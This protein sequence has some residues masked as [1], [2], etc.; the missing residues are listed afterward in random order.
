MK[1]KQLLSGFLVAMLFIFGCSPDDP[2]FIPVEDR[3][4][5]E[6]QLADNDSIINYLNTHYYN[7][8]ELLAMT[9]PTPRDIVLKE[10]TGTPDAGYSLLFGDENLITQTTTFEDTQYTFYVLKINQG[11]GEKSPNFTD[12]VRVLYEGSLVAQNNSVFDSAVTPAD[13]DLV[14][15]SVGIGVIQGW[16]NV[17]PFFNEAA[18]FTTG[19]S[20]TYDDFGL[21]VMFLPSGLAYFSSQLSGIPS[22]SNLIFKFA[23]LQTEVNDHDQDGIPSYIEDL[24]GNLNTFD[25]DT[26]EDTQPNYFDVDDDGDGVATIFELFPTEYIVDTNNNEPEPV[27][28]DG[29]FE[30]SRSEVSGIVTINT[31]TIVDDNNNGIAD[32]LDAEVTINYNE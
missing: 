16:Q 4:R 31:V 11:G 25:D 23:L 14:G 22:Y 32:Y 9:N 3:D 28:A 18:S 29:E 5:A 30:I 26:D 20:T 8:S 24:N 17:F 7:K 15:V 6:Q 10:F 21:G 12:K 1:L 13:F 2:T 19:S 27:L